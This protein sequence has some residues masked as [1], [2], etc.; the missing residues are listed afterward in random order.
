[1]YCSVYLGHA[2]NGSFVRFRY[3]GDP[4]QSGQTFVQVYM[5]DVWRFANRSICVC[6]YTVELGGINQVKISANIDREVELCVD[7]FM[8]LK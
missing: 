6:V 5:R 4:D 8:E 1:M 3:D 2:V 7:G